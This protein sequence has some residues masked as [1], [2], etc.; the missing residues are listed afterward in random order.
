MVEAM[1]MGKPILSTFNPA[2]PI[3]IEKEKMGLTV[4]YGDVEGWRQALK[5]LKDNPDEAKEM[6]ARALHICKT[7]LNYS[8]FSKEI[9]IFTGRR[10]TS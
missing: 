8:R 2:H 10:I 4:D 9:I 1:A 6:G 3:D 7:R 5:Y